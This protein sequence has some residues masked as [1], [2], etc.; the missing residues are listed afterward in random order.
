MAISNGLTGNGRR[1]HWSDSE[2]NDPEE[3]IELEE[4]RSI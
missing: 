3:R 1:D 4:P 2:I